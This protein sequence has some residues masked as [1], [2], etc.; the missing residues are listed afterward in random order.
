MAT[1]TL[2]RFRRLAPSQPPRPPLQGA[3]V[4]E[5]GQRVGPSCPQPTP[6]TPPVL[7]DGLEHPRCQPSAGLADKPLPRAVDPPASFPTTPPVAPEALRGVE[8][9]GLA[10]YDDQIW[11]VARLQGIPVVLSEDFPTGAVLEERAV[12]EP[13]PRWRWK[14]FEGVYRPRTRPDGC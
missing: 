6:T 11:A 2:L 4:E 14:A 9:H 13:N 3:A 8:A 12:L 5:G 10:F 7:H 1:C